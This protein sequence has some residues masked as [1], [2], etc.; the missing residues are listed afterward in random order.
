MMTARRSGTAARIV[1]WCNHTDAC[2]CNMPPELLDYSQNY[3]LHVRGETPHGHSRYN[4][5]DFHPRSVELEPAPILYVDSTRGIV[6]V[7]IS[8]RYTLSDD[9][10]VMYVIVLQSN[11]SDV[12]TFPRKYPKYV[13]PRSKLSPGATY[14]VRAQ[15]FHIISG[16]HSPFSPARCFRYQPEGLPKNLRV[17]AINSRYLLKWDWDYV[18]Y[19]NVTFSVE[20]CHLFN[21]E[22][23]KIA[24]CGNITVPLCDLSNEVYFYHTYSLRTSVY[25]SQRDEYNFSL[26]TF[27]PKTD[28]VM[29]PP[30]DI[31]ITIQDR[32]L[33][34][35]VSAPEGFNNE[36]LFKVCNWTY[37]LEYWKNTTHPQV[38][39]IE[40]PDPIFAPKDL[41]ASTTYCM[42]ARTKCVDD[43]H[44]AG[45]YSGI[46]CVTTDPRSYVTWWIAGSVV[47]A[48]ILIALVVY[49][50]FCPLK[51]YM[52][53]IFFPSS[54]LPAS[55]GKDM[56]D[57]PQKFGQITFALQEEEAFDRCYIIQEAQQEDLVQTD[58]S[59]A[60]SKDSGHYSIE[61]EGREETDV[62]TG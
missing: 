11:G 46:H 20:Q 58:T 57:S 10:L 15:L 12:E 8:T 43:E 37:H 62:C 17:E 36:N 28:A 2:V 48:V 47:I 30:T 19:P 14:C 16:M 41:K 50:C 45:L 52:K 40:R 35:V 6:I 23:K 27:H 34:I 42:K 44:R 51:R 24:A 33:H 53:H 1:H 54:K 60:R 18:Q 5:I 13:I 22:W 55:I 61:D 32:D 26:V 21:T 49:I 31:T 7:N 9:V 59:A 39:P 4:A 56:Q 3:T 25:D 29:G 38:I